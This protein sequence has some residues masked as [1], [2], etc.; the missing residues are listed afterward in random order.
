MNKLA[1]ASAALLVA[2]LA[3]PGAVGLIAEA[4][5]YD[6][7]AAID[8]DPRAAA[9]VRSYERGWFRSTARIDL[10]LVPDDVAALA[11]A[12]GTPLGAAS[13]L[14]VVV[15]YAHGPVAVLDGVHFGWGKF[16]VRPDTTDPGVDEITQTLG[17]PYLFEFRGRSGYLGRI[18]F[19]ADAP[20]FELPVEEV[21]VAFSG[22]TLRGSFASPRFRAD[23]RIGSV[24]IRSETGSFTMH[25]IDFSTD[26]EL[27]SEYVMPGDALFTVDTV[28]VG[29]G[30]GGT[31]AMETK[32]LRI[33]SET[34]VDAAGELLAM[35]LKYDVDSLRVE[36]NELTAGTV[37]VAVRNLDVAAVEAYG[38]LAA[39][40]AAA[41]AGPA[42]LAA[43][44]APH[45]ERAL[46]AGPSIALDPIRFRFNGEPFDGRIEVTTNT[47]GLPTAGR[48]SLDNPLMLLGAVNVNA[49]ARLS[50]PLAATLATLAARRQL[51]ADPTIPPEQVD[52]MAEA[53][54][55][56]MLTMLVGQ[57]VLVEDGD[58]YTSSFSYTNGAITLNGNPLPFG[59]P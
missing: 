37:S 51:A 26:S 8:A 15:E 6:R 24:D 4:R 21:L 44:L 18:D 13:S 35:R 23:A 42:A 49:Y 53:Q 31:P 22:A 40:A 39:D 5:V 48:L 30:L 14:P 16:V 1:V 52:Y 33:A 59:L 38:E 27:R 3:L 55:G 34:A 46:R 11:E 28:S 57:G 47:A 2:L 45:F 43:S 7:V 19:D 25:G 41:G 54:S 10:R 58:G 32:N 9:E 17:V 50:K 56:L 29:D 12:N 36:D 20:P